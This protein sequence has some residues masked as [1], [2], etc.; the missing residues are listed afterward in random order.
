MSSC[1]DKRSLTPTGILKQSKV[2]VNIQMMIN[3]DPAKLIWGFEMAK[4]TLFECN[5]VL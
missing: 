1:F 3:A 5:V 4:V 2:S